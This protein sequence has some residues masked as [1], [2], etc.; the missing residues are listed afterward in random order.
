[1]PIF[2]Q[3]L[4]ASAIQFVG[5]RMK[6][7]SGMDCGLRTTPRLSEA[8]FENAARPTLLELDVEAYRLRLDEL[9]KSTVQNLSLAISRAWRSRPY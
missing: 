4:W 6:R 8:A 9:E 3:T 7:V 1:M 5:M 2:Y